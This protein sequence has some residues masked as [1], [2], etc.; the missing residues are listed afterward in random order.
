MSTLKLE[1]SPSTLEIFPGTSTL[2]NEFQK[3]DQIRDFGLYQI[4]FLIVREFRK[5]FRRNVFVSK[6]TFEPRSYF[7]T[8]WKNK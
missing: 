4:Y 7:K 3:Y 1:E 5:Y 2:E 6:C 8:N